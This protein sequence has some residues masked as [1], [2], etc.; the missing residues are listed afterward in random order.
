MALGCSA[1][2]PARQAKFRKLLRLNFRLLSDTEKSVLKA[3]GVWQEK[4]FLG[5]KFMGV[6][7]STAIIGP[8]GRIKK[9]FEAVRPGK[10]AS[11]VLA[12]L[13]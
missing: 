9:V 7:R 6:A 10:H 8:D 11:E 3:Y 2:P 5:K 12:A 1:D 4:S 13:E